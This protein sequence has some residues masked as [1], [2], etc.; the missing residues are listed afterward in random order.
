MFH[1]IEFRT[2]RMD[3][4]AA[5]KRACEICGAA[6]THA[7]EEARGVRSAVCVA[8]HRSYWFRGPGGIWETSEERMA[9]MRREYC[10]QICGNKI[11]TFLDLD[12]TEYVCMR[13]KKKATQE[14]YAKRRASSAAAVRPAD[15]RNRSPW[16]QFQF[17]A[18]P[19]GV[20]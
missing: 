6:L 17:H 14:Y 20:R 15:R 1:A 8:G 16:R 10:C 2:P 7:A 13:C 19:R 9:R 11:T 18:M 5:A 4:Y 12:A 3:D